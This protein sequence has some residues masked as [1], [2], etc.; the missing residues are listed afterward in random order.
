M[1]QG[2]Q[3]RADKRDPQAPSSPHAH[4]TACWQRNRCPQSSAPTLL[5]ALHITPRGFPTP[6]ERKN[7]PIIIPGLFFFSSF[8]HCLYKGCMYQ[9]LYSS[10]SSIEKIVINL[11]WQS[12]PC[13]T[14]DTRAEYSSAGREWHSAFCSAEIVLK[15]LSCTGVS[16]S[17]EILLLHTRSPGCLLHNHVLSASY[18]IG[19]TVW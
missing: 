11:P 4:P 9:G 18:K 15:T 14:K 2:T 19:C 8:L 7:H 10:K 16:Y 1:P 6:G 3:L 12:H 13:P 17:K 5:C